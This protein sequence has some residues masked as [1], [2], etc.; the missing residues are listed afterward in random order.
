MNDKDRIEQVALALCQL[1]DHEPK[2]VYF[3]AAVCEAVRLVAAFEVLERMREPP[4]APPKPRR[5]TGAP[6]PVATEH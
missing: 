5:R 4:P 2:G 1:D 3:G 6:Q